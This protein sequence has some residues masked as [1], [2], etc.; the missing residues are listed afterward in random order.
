MQELVVPALPSGPPGALVFASE[1]Q[2]QLAQHG[3]ID[4]ERLGCRCRPGNR[5]T[6]FRIGFNY[7]I[8]SPID[9]LLGSERTTSR[10]R[11]GMLARL[12]ALPRVQQPS[13]GFRNSKPRNAKPATT[14]A[15]RLF[16][17]VATNRR[18]ANWVWRVSPPIRQP[19]T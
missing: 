14:V 11:S 1:P 16:S 19:N 18:A 5:C 13:R 15:S 12:L 4:D 9:A 7:R 10:T 3:P 2:L 17:W 6:P 8:T